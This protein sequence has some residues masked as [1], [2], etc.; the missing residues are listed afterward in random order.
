MLPAYP[1]SA[2]NALAVKLLLLTCTR[3]GEL[4]K[5]EWAHVVSTAPN[6][7]CPTPIP[8]LG[9]ASPCR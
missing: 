9:R 6:G 7:L 3:I 1:V 2:D 4:A 5:A 8:R